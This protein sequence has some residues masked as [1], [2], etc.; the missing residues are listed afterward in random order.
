MLKQVG[1]KRFE[2]LMKSI[3]KMIALMVLVFASFV[4]FVHGA[5][6]AVEVPDSFKVKFEQLPVEKPL[7]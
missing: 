4:M 1:R 7:L 3:I 5:E 6:D 2:G